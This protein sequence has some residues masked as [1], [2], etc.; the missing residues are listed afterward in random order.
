M[1]AVTGLGAVCPVGLGMEAAW[2]SLLAGT[3]GI[4][5]ITSFDTTDFSVRIAGQVAPFDPEAYLPRQDCRRFD[6]YALYGIVAGIQALTDAGIGP[7]DVE[8]ERFSIVV[9]TGY[10]CTAAN[11]AA[12]RL[13]DDKGPSRFGP[14]PAVY[15]AQDIVATYLSLRYQ[16]LGEAFSVSAACASGNVAVGQGH[17]LVESGEADVVL[18]IG[19]EGAVE[20]RDLAIVSGSRA[21]TAT[22]N[23]SPG[24]ASRPFDRGRDGFVLSAGGAAL[25]LE[26]EGHARRRGAS[27]LARLVAYGAAS[28]GH[29]LTAPHPQGRGAVRAMRKALASAGVRLGDRVHVNAHGTSTPLNDAIEAQ[30]IV[31]VFGSRAGEIPVT[32]T[33]S[34]TGH[35]IGAA[36]T[37]EA[38]ASVM[39]LRTGWVPPTANCDDPEFAIDVVRGEA[40]KV[41][42]TW[43]MS[44]SFG[45]GG[46]C[47][48]IVLAAG[49]G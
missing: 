48:S 1:T 30:A 26:S 3:S 19:S 8:P 42:P 2:E 28:D 34:L 7:D 24:T 10:G 14:G 29:H 41:D 17:R 39:A 15:G 20:P 31:E 13:L 12:V 16:A 5:G 18:V 32:S 44:N 36:G 43:V 40:R 46:H 27:T 25:V 47:T 11:T 9:G 33:K 6:S 38:A 35:M 45:F 49:D 4:S 22:H 21:L 23:N 37:F